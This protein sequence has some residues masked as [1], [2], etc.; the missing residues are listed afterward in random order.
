MSDLAEL[1]PKLG[2]PPDEDPADAAVRVRRW[3]EETD[4]GWLLVF[5][6]VPDEASIDR[7]R[8]KRGRGSVLVTSRNRNLDGIGEVVDVA[9]FDTAMSEQFLRDRV[10]PRNP[11]AAGEPEARDV[12]TKAPNRRFARYRELFD[13]AGKD[14]FPDGTR[15]TGYDATAFSTWRVSVAAAKAEAP[16]AERLL[17]A[18][19]Y[20]APDRIPLRYFEGES[21]A[22][23]RYLGATSA[24]VEAALAALHGYSLVDLG[25]DSLSVHRVVQASALRTG[26]RE[27]AAFAIRVLR[28][29]ATGDARNHL[30]WPALR[31]LT[32]HAL[33]A[34]DAARSVDHGEGPA[35]WY[36]SSTTS[37]RFS[38]LAAR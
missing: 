4:R 27:A 17:W 14:P 23:D 26:D 22:A 36:V 10:K 2:L 37:P 6:N 15:P 13:D 9:V 1:A 38:V 8:P 21:V 16:P 35:L 31:E 7:W 28:A 24:E 12:A 18:L 11:A 33:H 3:L 32:P 25:A 20:F 5:D 29:Q 30:H 19:A 34:A